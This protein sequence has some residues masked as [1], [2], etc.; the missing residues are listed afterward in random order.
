MTPLS[1]WRERERLHTGH[2]ETTGGRERRVGE[3]LTSVR[4]PAAEV[5]VEPDG[6]SAAASDRHHG[7]VGCHEQLLGVGEAGQLR[8][9]GLT[10]LTHPRVHGEA[11]S[12]SEQERFTCARDTE[13]RAINRLSA[14][15]DREGKQYHTARDEPV[16]LAAVAAVSET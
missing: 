5:F 4:L 6:L 15:G 7:V 14:G 13:G 1:S 3:G 10:Q 11:G 8:V 12:E 2:I 16:S 9:L